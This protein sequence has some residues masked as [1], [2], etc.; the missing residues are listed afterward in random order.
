[1]LSAMRG[2]ANYAW[3]N[4]QCITHL[5]RVALSTTL[6]I[7]EQDL[8]MDLIY[9]VAHNIAKIEEHTIN[10]KKEKLCIHRK[11]ATRSL[12]A[13]HPLL[14]QRYQSIGQPVLIPGDMGRHSFV[15]VGTERSMSETFGSTCHGAGRLQSR[16]AAKKQLKGLQV[17]NDLA[18][19][20]ITVRTGNVH[21]LAEE[22][23]EAYKDVTSIV[24]VVHNAGISRLVFRTRPLGVVKG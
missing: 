4:R 1:Y 12:P 23:P 19:R 17:L 5:C 2:A 20:G 10:G 16:K 13:G 8:G 11:G 9:D 24:N 3:A 18:A 6:K 15:L 14:P 22:A 21:D 7:S